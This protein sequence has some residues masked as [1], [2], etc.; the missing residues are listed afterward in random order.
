MMSHG[1]WRHQI[2]SS[3]S[4]Q[5]DIWLNA[6]WIPVNSQARALFIIINI[7]FKRE[8]YVKKC[9]LCET[10][11]AHYSITLIMKA[12]VS[13][14]SRRCVCVCFFVIWLLYSTNKSKINH[15]CNTIYLIS[16]QN[17]RYDALVIIFNFMTSYGDVITMQCQYQ[18]T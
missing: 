16:A 4:K 17:V 3:I 14:E 18:Y 9:F 10:K 11:I 8:Y 15:A 12:V 1:T 2:T 5:K 13:V 6:D 7:F